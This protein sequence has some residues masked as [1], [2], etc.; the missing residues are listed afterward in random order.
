MNTSSLGSSVASLNE[1]TEQNQTSSSDSKLYRYKQGVK[2][3]V[4][5]YPFLKHNSSFNQ[6]TNC[7]E[8]KD[9]CVDAVKKSLHKSHNT[10]SLQSMCFDGGSIEGNYECIAQESCDSMPICCDHYK[11][12]V[13]PKGP[14]LSV[15]PKQSDLKS[16][17]ISSSLGSSGED[18]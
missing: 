18:G 10:G 7:C 5:S 11:S 3:N 1:P 2:I 9:Q 4:S 15:P 16:S 13:E 8:N 6:I 12:V 17:D 14:M